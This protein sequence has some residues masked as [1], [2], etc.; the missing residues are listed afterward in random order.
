MGGE[1]EKA[2]RD[3]TAGMFDALCESCKDEDYDFIEA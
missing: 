1:L 2:I 3:L